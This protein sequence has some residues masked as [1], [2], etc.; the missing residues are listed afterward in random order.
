MI[1]IVGGD[2]IVN[3]ETYTIESQS[4]SPR[5]PSPPPLV[6]NNEMNDDELIFVLEL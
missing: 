5:P 2:G 6:G 1:R 3:V 4:T